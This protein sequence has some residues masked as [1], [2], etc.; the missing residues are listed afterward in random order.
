MCVRDVSTS[1][2]RRGEM[3]LLVRRS[4]R[5][6]TMH[7]MWSAISGTINEGED[8]LARAYVEI[9]E[10]TRI[11]SVSLTL[12]GSAPPALVDSPEH[13]GRLRIYGFLFETSTARVTLNWE[14]SEYAWITRRGIDSLDTVPRLGEILDSLL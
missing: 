3:Y 13:G 6:S 7:G 14:S 9:L 2:L 10:E 5:V 11:P 1:F 8:A 12:L 4:A